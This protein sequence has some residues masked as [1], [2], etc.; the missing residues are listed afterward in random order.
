S[1]E[2][3]ALTPAAAIDRLEAIYAGS[4]AA[5]ARALDRYLATRKAPTAKD[6]AAFRYPLLRVECRHVGAA[7]R[8]RR[9]FAK[10]QRPGVYATTVTHPRHFRKYLMEQLEPLVAEYAAAITVDVSAPD[11]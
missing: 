2:R 6:R 10:F 1:N 4:C 9:A 3:H 8:T 11:I 5:L 7:A